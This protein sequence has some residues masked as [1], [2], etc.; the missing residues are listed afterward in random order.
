MHAIVDTFDRES[1]LC[2]LHT[3]FVS[4]AQMIAEKT[5][6]LKRYDSDYSMFL[7]SMQE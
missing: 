1:D 7:I 6:M 3:F 2:Y 4:Q 5:L